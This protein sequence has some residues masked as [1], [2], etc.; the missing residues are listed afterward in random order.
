MDIR[1]LA[2]VGGFAVGAALTFAPFA[3]ADPAAVPDPLL[4]FVDSEIAS[5]NALFVSEADL[6]GVGK[7]VI[8]NGPTRSTPS[9]WRTHQTREPPLS[10]TSSCTGS[11]R[12][13]MQP[14]TRVLSASSMARWSISTTPTTSS[15]SRC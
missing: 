7:D 14:L 10:S 8:T 5:M 1:K 11:T 3:S 12:L 13:P 15:C 6:A 2:V 4:P 9:H